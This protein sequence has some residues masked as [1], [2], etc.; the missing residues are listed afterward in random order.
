ML[1]PRRCMCSCVVRLHGLMEMKY[2]SLY[3]SVALYFVLSTICVSANGL[4]A[5]TSDEEVAEKSFFDIEEQAKLV[6]DGI[7]QTG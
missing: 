3:W 5:E 1:R 7:C 4:Y 6:D 2:A